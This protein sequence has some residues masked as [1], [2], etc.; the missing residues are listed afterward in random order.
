M[1]VITLALGMMALAACSDGTGPD[2]AGTGRIR[3]NL[4]TLPVPAG[5]P[6]LSET[7]TLGGTTLVLSRV[8]LVVKEIELKRAEDSSTCLDDAE[9]ESDDD[10]EEIEFGPILLELPLNG[11]VSQVLTVEADTGTYRELEFEIHKPEDG[12][13]D[14]IFLAQ[15]PDFRRV[16]I[17]A[18]GTWN[19]TPFVFLSE[20]GVEQELDLVPPLRIEAAGSTE[21]TLRVDLRSWFLNSGGTAFINPATANKGQSAESVVSENIKRSFEAFENDD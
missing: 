14:A 1:R 11:S 3:L 20:L 21:L 15:H 5:G 10:C 8:Q 18:E 2:T 19:G 17:R 7:Y 9:G 6:A 12:G 16:S 4:S 13:E